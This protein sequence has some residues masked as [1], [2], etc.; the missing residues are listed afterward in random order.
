MESPK[1]QIKEQKKKKNLFRK[2]VGMVI[3]STQEIA[4][5]QSNTEN[6]RNICVL[7]HVDHGK[8]VRFFPIPLSLYFENIKKKER[9]KKKK[10]KNRI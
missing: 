4:S 6:I 5:M 3:V 8:T 9:E 1:K 2:K 7:A 10:K